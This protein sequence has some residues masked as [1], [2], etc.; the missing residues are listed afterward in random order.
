MHGK[1]SSAGWPVWVPALLVAVCAVAA[2]AHGLYEVAVAAGVPP[3]LAWT[4]PASADGLALVAYAS[5]HRLRGLASG[6]AWGVTVLAAGLSGLAQGV[7]L[8]SDP[9]VAVTALRFGVGVWPALAAALVAHLL[10][11]LANPAKP[12]VVPMPPRIV[13][14]AVATVPTR[15]AVTA[16]VEPAP[17]PAV[18]TDLDRVR[19]LVADGAGRNIVARELG[20]KPHVARRLVEQVK[21]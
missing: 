4:Y 11:L 2:T 16:A 14:D 21:Q 8:A 13:A 7:Y 17:A 10:Y 6:Y 9:V 19:K 5:T 20:V 1:R 12:P 15:P 3:A 18:D